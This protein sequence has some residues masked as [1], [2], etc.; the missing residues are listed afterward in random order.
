[1]AAIR[2]ARKDDLPDILEISKSVWGGHDYLPR[3]INDWLKDTNCHTFGIEVDGK[4]IA[5]AN[6]RV[7]D[8][9]KTAWFEGLRVHPEHRGQGYANSLTD[10]LVKVSH[11]LGVERIR[12][13]TASDNVESLALANRIG[14]EKILEMYVFWKGDLSELNWSYSEKEVLQASPRHVQEL[15]EENISDFLHP[16][17]IHDWKAWEFTEQYLQNIDHKCCYYL[18]WRKERVSGLSVGGI[19]KEADNDQWSFTIYATDEEAFLSHLS[20]H[21]DLA[22]DQQFDAVMCIAE[23][24]FQTIIEGLPWFTEDIHGTRIILFD[25]EFSQ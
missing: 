22:C 15:L 10:H 25:K 17:I 13:T 7:I 18:S 20:Y 23:T 6:L 11:D 19:R 24:G 12:Y 2:N 21:L 5:I 1:M 4:L 9:G 14:L 16:V 3:Q 8:D